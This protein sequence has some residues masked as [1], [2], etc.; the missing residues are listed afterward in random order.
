MKPEDLTQKHIDVLKFALGKQF[1]ISAVAK[2]FKWDRALA[3]TI[4]SQLCNAKLVVQYDNYSFGVT[5]SGRDKLIELGFKEAERK[6]KGFRPKKERQIIA[7]TN[8]SD[9]IV[10][11]AE[12]LDAMAASM[13][14]AVEVDQPAPAAPSFNYE[15]QHIEVVPSEPAESAALVH[16][17]INRLLEKLNGKPAIISNAHFKFAALNN[18]ASGIEAAEPNVAALLRE[19]AMDI[20]NAAGLGGDK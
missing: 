3:L 8:K 2:N 14:M 11:S 17:G 15:S 5:S 10:E 13:G 16:S 20:H 1:T 4:V 12:H 18:L 19:V 9:V 7:D 6:P